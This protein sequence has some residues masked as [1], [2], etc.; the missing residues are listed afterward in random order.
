MLQDITTVAAVDPSAITDR[1]T[2][3]LELLL[4]PTGGKAS[5]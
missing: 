3:T 4:R 1:K 2:T 5:R